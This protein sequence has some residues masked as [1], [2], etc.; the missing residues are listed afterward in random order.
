M[1]RGHLNAMGG[2]SKGSPGMQSPDT[3]LAFHRT[4]K[5][6]YP[7][8]PKPIYL[9]PS[10]SFGHLW[11]KVLLYPGLIELSQPIKILVVCN[12]QFD[13]LALIYCSGLEE[14]S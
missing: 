8:G 3:F 5:R 9:A 4:N 6:P 7:H 13:K 1:L 14:K 12:I 10:Q 2:Q 11:P